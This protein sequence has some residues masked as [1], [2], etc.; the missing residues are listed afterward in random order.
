[1]AH[2]RVSLTENRSVSVPKTSTKV[3]ADDQQHYE[4]F[5][6]WHPCLPAEV[7]LH[8]VKASKTTQLALAASQKACCR[9]TPPLACSVL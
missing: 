3:L 6:S 5:H 4:L 9:Y 8:T 7:T 1:M 2:L